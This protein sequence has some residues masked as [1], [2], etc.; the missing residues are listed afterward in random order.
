[1]AT[2]ETINVSLETYERIK[3]QAQAR[4]LS[5]ERFLEYLIQEFTEAREREFIE[6]L[7]A[8]GWI[9]SCPS[10]KVSKP[11]NF[12]P[13]PFKG[14]PVSEILIEDRGPR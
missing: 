2:T 5:I 4:R 6:H 13:L 10:S 3:K 11:R 8:K 12:K 1:M 9:A 14:K 7:R